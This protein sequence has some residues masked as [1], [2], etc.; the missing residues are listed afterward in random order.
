MME[1]PGEFLAV[2][3]DWL[4]RHGSE[5]GGAVAVDREVDLV[6]KPAVRPVRG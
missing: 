6:A 2:T 1:V 5:A 4:T 3:G